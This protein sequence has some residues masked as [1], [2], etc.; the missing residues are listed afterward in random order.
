[1]TSRAAPLFAAL[2]ALPFAACHTAHEAPFAGQVEH[3]VLVWLKDGT[4]AEKDAVKA[5]LVATA[6]TFPAQIAGLLSVTAGDGV[7]LTSAGGASAAA[8]ETCDL[9]FVMRFASKQALDAYQVHPVHTRAVADVL[10]PATRRVVSH[11][12]VIR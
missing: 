3:V 1:M 5:K 10:A 4:A 12:A 11:D 2:L 9:M 7:P 6:N 8:D